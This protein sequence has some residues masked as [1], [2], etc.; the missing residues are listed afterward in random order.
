MDYEEW[1]DEALIDECGRLNQVISMTEAIGSQ[2]N[3]DLDDITAEL[4]DR[5][6]EVYTLSEVTV[7]KVEVEA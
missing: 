5:G 1:T 2:N 4:E 6:Y 3:Q 7:E